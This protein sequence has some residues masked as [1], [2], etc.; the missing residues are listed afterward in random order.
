MGTETDLTSFHLSLLVTFVVCVHTPSCNTTLHFT[1]CVSFS[2]LVQLV[3][4]Y[5]KHIA[6][7]YILSSAVVRIVGPN[8]QEAKHL[9]FVFS[10]IALESFVSKSQKVYWVHLETNVVSCNTFFL[11]EG[12]DVQFL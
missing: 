8:C 10:T 9:H 2:Q 7:A 1:D 3:D 11:N 4:I 12:Y 6:L 5:T